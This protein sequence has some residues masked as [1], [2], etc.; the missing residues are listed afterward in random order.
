M[1]MLPGMPLDVVYVALGGT[2]MLCSL[3]ML[4]HHNY[5]LHIPQLP[6]MAT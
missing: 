4:C 2:L 5:C 3:L 1:A 6:Q